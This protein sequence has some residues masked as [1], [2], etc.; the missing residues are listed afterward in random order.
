MN[1]ILFGQI[2]VRSHF[3]GG[4]TEISQLELSLFSDGP[5]FI[6]NATPL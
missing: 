1:Y 3:V 6:H 5:L 2:L 4:K